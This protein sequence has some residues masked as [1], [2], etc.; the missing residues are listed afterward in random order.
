MIEPLGYGKN[1]RGNYI[2]LIKFTKS[3]PKN[4]G[5]LWEKTPYRVRV[6]HQR[7]AFGF[8]PVDAHLQALVRRVRVRHDLH[9]AQFRRDHFDADLLLLNGGG[10]MKIWP[11]IFGILLVDLIIDHWC[12]SLPFLGLFSVAMWI[13]N[14][15]DFWSLDSPTDH[16]LVWCVFTLCHWSVINKSWSLALTSL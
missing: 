3:R 16:D 14:D 12:W 5:F 2:K 8:L 1:F 15:H 7:A 11:L 9:N 10:A 13:I 4:I 6:D